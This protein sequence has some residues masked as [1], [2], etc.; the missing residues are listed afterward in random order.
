LHE[1][2]REKQGQFS[3]Q[4]AFRLAANQIKQAAKDTDLDENPRYKCRDMKKL[5]EMTDEGLTWQ[6]EAASS[7]I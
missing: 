1:F 4:I 2:V 7:S 5:H 3:Q 6:G